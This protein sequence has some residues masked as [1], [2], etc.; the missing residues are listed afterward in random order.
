MGRGCQLYWYDRVNF[1]PM[2]F[3]HFLS[4]SMRKRMSMN[5][6]SVP[7]GLPLYPGE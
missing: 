5:G 1:M 4:M 7:K 3:P 2:R 6:E